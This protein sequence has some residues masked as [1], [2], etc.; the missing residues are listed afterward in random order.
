MAAGGLA[1]GLE[2]LFERP[3]LPVFDLSESLRSAYGG[4]FG[5]REDCVYANFVASIDGVVALRTEEE[6]GHIISGGSEADR[7]VM[8]LLRACADAVLLGAGTFRKAAGHLWHAEAIYPPA[9]SQFAEFRRRLGLRRQPPLVVVSATG[10]IDA[11]QPAL[12]DAIVVTTAAGEA[13]LK[14]RVPPT[15]R[16][17]SG[18]IRLASVLELLRAEGHRRILTEGGPTLASE[19]AAEGLLNELFLTR[20]PMLFG[21]FSGDGRKGL[22]EGVDLAGR[23]ADLVGVRR[24]GSYL[25]LRY[26]VQP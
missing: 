25:F 3:G 20:S 19:L 21:R 10:E 9:A 24:Q 15:T 26:C 8:G 12:R 22:V 13:R 6:S 7:F 18:P 1:K 14:G 5:L 17:V 16:F 11:A 23:M 2:L 4:P